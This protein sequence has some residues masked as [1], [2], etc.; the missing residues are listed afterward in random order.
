MPDASVRPRIDQAVE[1]RSNLIGRGPEISPPQNLDQSLDLTRGCEGDGVEASA[2]LRCRFGRP[3]GKIKNNAQSRPCE[4]I[5]EVMGR[6][7]ALALPIELK[8]QLVGLDR[9]SVV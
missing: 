7:H 6:G 3:L 8:G 2:L 4:L 9:K 1:A 5:L